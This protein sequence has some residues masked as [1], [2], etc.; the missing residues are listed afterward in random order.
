[1]SFRSRNQRAS[2]RRSSPAA[3]PFID[4]SKPVP[5]AYTCQRCG[6]D[7]TAMVALREVVRFDYEKPS[8]CPL[9]E[10]P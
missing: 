7:R 8:L 5:I 3:G 2:I 4:Y 1:M 10:R 6:N 9:C